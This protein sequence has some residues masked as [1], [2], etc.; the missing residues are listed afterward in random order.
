MKKLGLIPLVVLLLSVF[1]PM[2]FAGDLY[3]YLRYDGTDDY[4]NVPDD[5]SLNVTSETCTIEFWLRGETQT[6]YGDYLCMF[7]DE[8]YG[9]QFV[10][11]YMEDNLFFD[12]YDPEDDGFYLTS[13]SAVLDGDWHHVLFLRNGTGAELWIDGVLEDSE[14]NDLV[15]SLDTNVSLT[16]GYNPYE[17]DF[18]DG[19]IDEVRIYDRNITE[20]EIAYSFANKEPQNQAGLVIWLRFNEG[21]GDTTYDETDNNN[22]GTLM[23]DYPS[24]APEWVDETPVENTTPGEIV[25]NKMR[26]AALTMAAIMTVFVILWGISGDGRL[27][28]VLAYLI[29]IALILLIANVAGGIG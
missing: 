25:R 22:D 2:V 9:W 18:F 14:I 13:D 6:G 3:K 15:G 28:D 12:S 5:A 29:T 1:A 23:P 26:T 20:A 11:G 4:V 24:N 27:Q 8:G 7:T 10:K 19:D 17:D 21:T 16:I